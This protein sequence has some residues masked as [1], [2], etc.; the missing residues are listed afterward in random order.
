MQ[1]SAIGKPS[2]N[3]LLS[4]RVINETNLEKFHQSLNSADLSDVF[5]KTDTNDSFT[6]FFGIINNAFNHH[7]PLLTRKF[8]PNNFK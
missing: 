6:T 2:I 1:S 5:L 8:K 3:P 7:F 4:N